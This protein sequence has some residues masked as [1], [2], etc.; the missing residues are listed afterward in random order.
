[1]RFIPAFAVLSYTVRAGCF[2]YFFADETLTD[3]FRYN[4]SELSLS[5]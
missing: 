4:S 3:D 1:M 2:S 5:L